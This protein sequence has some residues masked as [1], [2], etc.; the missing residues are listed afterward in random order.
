[1]K[2]VFATHNPN[3]LREIQEL[4][5]PFIELISLE[6]LGCAA[7]IPETADTLE[8]NARLKADFITTTY[9]LP[10]FA[11]DTGLLVTALDG[12]PGVL[13]A[14][15]AGLESTTE[16]NVNKILNEIKNSDD[17]TAHFKTVIAFNLNAKTHLF[18]GIIDGTI[19]YEK[20]GDNGFG[21]DPIFRP[22]G[23]EHT[24]AELPLSA[25]N[26]ISH[27]GQAF[28]KLI[29]FLTTLDPKE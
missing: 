2:L 6:S 25:K 24:F 9:N 27:R 12:A 20:Q 10:C 23:Y 7:K 14:R 11:D 8:G 22:V 19:T 5:P 17:R 26:E 16:A 3:K 1:M 28:R 15:Y 29:A 4:V 13:S 21:Y 18:E